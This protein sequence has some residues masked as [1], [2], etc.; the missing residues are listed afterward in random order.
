MFSL[1]LRRWRSVAAGAALSCA[2]GTLLVAQVRPSRQDAE[3][4]KR[5]VAAIVA[6]GQRSSKQP[7][8]TTLTEVEVNSY[9]AYELGGTLPAG[10]VDPSVTAPGDGRVM[11]RAVVDLDAVRKAAQSTSLLD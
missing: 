8:R 2:L 6:Q 7:L 11:G 4:M 5:K 3:S 1:C 10:V 9:L